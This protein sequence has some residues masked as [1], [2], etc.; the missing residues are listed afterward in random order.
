M[1]VAV[2][3]V[4]GRRQQLTEYVLENNKVTARQMEAAEKP[5]LFAK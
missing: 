3:G 1:N 2:S 5:F 4:K